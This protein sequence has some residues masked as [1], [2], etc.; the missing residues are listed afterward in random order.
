MKTKQKNVREPSRGQQL[1]GCSPN[2][3]GWRVAMASFLTLMLLSI[4]AVPARAVAT[5]SV[6]VTNI[7]NLTILEDAAATNV[8]FH[9][10]AYAGAAGVLN[11]TSSVPALV[12]D[13]VVA[14]IAPTTDATNGTL[15]FTP[16]ANKNGTATITLWVTNDLPS[17]NSV[18][19][20]VIVTAVNDAPSFTLATNNLQIYRTNGPYSGANFA[21]NMSAGPSDEAS[22]T[23]SFI[24]T[25]NF[26]AGFFSTPPQIDASGTLTFEVTTNKYGTNTV[27]VVLKDNGEPGSADLVSF[28]LWSKN[29]QLLFSSNWYG[30]KTMPQVLDGGNI[31]VH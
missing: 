26:P 1:N 9:I 5:N 19:F 13:P 12:P 2:L 6:I 29:G 28:T 15:T 24:V 11:A 4:W 16:A 17:T 21:T 14:L 7:P 10:R 23:L 3:H 20:D 30:V 27:T 25:T 18:A 8:A 22:Q 31:Q